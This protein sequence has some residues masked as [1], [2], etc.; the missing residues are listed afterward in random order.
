MDVQ[1]STKSYKNFMNLCY[2]EA[3]LG[4]KAT[5]SFFATSHGKSPCDGVGGTVKRKITRASMQRPVTDQILTFDAVIEYCQ[6]SIS[7]IK[8]FVIMTEDMNSQYSCDVGSEVRVRKYGNQIDACSLLKT[9][10]PS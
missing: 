9:L 10:W 4:L 1:D 5:W 7:G 2:H 8:F 3:D 6:S